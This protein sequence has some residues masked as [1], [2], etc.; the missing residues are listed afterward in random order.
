MK[1]FL[2]GLPIVL[3]I[4]FGIYYI[5][6]LDD[7][8]LFCLIS[9]LSLTAL[10]PAILRQRKI[11]IFEPI[12]LVYSAVAIGCPA[13]AIL[14][15]FFGSEKFDYL[16]YGY[17]FDELNG[18]AS[19]MILGLFSFAMAY[20]IVLNKRKPFYDSNFFNRKLCTRKVRAVC[21]LFLLV[22][23]TGSLM[24]MS[25]TGVDF[26]NAETI[27][28]KRA[29]L[30]EEAAAENVYSSFSHL[31]FLAS[32]ADMGF[33]LFL[34]TI[35][36]NKKK[37]KLVDKVLLVILFLAACVTPFVSSSR[38]D[39]M[40]LMIN[41]SIIFYYFNQ[42]K[43][44][45]KITIFSLIF[46]VFMAA[47]MGYL[48]ANAQGNESDSYFNPIEATVGSGNFVD[49]ARTGII[50][51]SM[52][53]K[54]DYLY[55]ESLV[56]FLIFPIPRVIWPEKPNV[57]LGPLVRS[58]IYNLPTKNNGFPPGLVAEGYMNFGLIGILLVPALYGIV[59]ALF[60]SV[61]SSYLHTQIGLILY[62]AVIWR[63]A[64]VGAG[65]N[66][67]QTIAQI[68]PDFIILTLICFVTSKRNFNESKYS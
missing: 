24:F 27:S 32:F 59:L 5:A 66:F 3:S 17:T 68:V 40:L 44:P 2:I 36:F 55:G 25:N 14:V 47:F 46:V 43:I 12:I 4:F 53:R 56:T 45:I 50:I 8:I 41:A 11:D 67:S 20:A 21:L 6:N 52:P 51:D 57:S 31:K 1:A 10:I 29:V 16:T 30:I 19:L 58:E 49:L 7:G 9:S 60:Y 13:R 26:S 48:R 65:L 35:L 33:L 18:P 38:M 22:S 54:L 39:I 15:V 64:F 42:K 37:A 23:L 61:F 34:T 63:F 28:N 62:G